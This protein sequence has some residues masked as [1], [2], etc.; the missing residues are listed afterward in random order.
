VEVSY[1]V[2]SL[3]CYLFDFITYITLA[4]FAVGIVHFSPNFRFYLSVVVCQ[5]RSVVLFGQSREQREVIFRI[6]VG[7][8]LY[9]FRAVCNLN[10]DGQCDSYIRKYCENVQKH[11]LA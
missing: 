3:S 8:G 2:H 5:N 9:M 6:S 7:L 1:A 11:C 4:Q 10:V